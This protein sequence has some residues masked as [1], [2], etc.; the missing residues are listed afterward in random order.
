M[1]KTKLASTTNPK[2]RFF[3]GANTPSGFVSKFDQLADPLSGQTLFV[4]KGGPGSG[5]SSV[6][7]KAAAAMEELG[8]SAEY[9]HCSSDADSLDAVIFPQLGCAVA[10]GTPPHTIEPKYPG[11]FEQVIFLND[12]WDEKPLNANRKKII[13]LSDDIAAHHRRCCRYLA[14]ASMLQNE[15]TQIVSPLTD[16]QK[17]ERYAKGL[18]SRLFP[19]KTS[20]N[21]KNSLRFLS[22]V[23]NKG[24]VFFAETLT[25]L[26]DEL[27]VIDDRWGVASK[28]LLTKLR[29]SALSC[30]LDTVSCC[31]PLSACEKT[32]H[33]IL[34][35]LKL[36]FV[37]CT[38]HHK[39]DAAALN[40]VPKLHVI[41]AERFTDTEALRRK[42]Q[43]IALTEKMTERLLTDA[44]NQLLLA[45][46]LHDELE[47]L[48]VSAMDFDK[49]HQKADKLIL[50]LK[51]HIK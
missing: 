11:A 12:C 31:C 26:C 34:P 42:R 47:S 41:H 30:G 8:I 6:M 25:A 10:D 13:S 39:I 18:A 50:L 14:I 28:L 4:I 1:E 23:T 27:Y 40:A 16:T 38:P 49:V 9:I 33:L 48:Y 36:A 43:R 20:V 51:E 21:G 2:R 44:E 24:R 17:A 5:K 35:Q 46:R 32:E 37:S 3:L 19:K 45:K 7:K 15:I 29:A 22:A